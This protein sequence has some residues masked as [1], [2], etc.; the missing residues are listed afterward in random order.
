M[1]EFKVNIFFKNDGCSLQ[2]L[3]NEL[4]LNFIKSN[5]DATCNDNNKEL[6]YS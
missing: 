3:M 6:L 5:I 2:F 1:N 4:F